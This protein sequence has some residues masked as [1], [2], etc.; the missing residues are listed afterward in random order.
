MKNAQ[1]AVDSRL[2]HT[3]II[4]E[5]QVLLNLGFIFCVKIYYIK[6]RNLKGVMF[7]IYINKKIIIKMMININ[8]Y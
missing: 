6:A 8:K 2:V 5:S 4:Q 7:K 3:I 1:N